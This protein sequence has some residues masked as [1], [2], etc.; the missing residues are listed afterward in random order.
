[1]K[2]LLISAGILVVFNVIF[3]SEFKQY[4]LK[5]KQRPGFENFSTEGGRTVLKDGEFQ[6]PNYREG[7]SGW[8]VSSEGNAEFQDVLINNA[9]IDSLFWNRLTGL[10]S[11]ESFDGFSTKGV[12]VSVFTPYFMGSKIATGATDDNFAVLYS[13]P[14]AQNGV[15][16]SISAQRNPRFQINCRVQDA[17][18]A[19]A[20]VG[21]SSVGA[22]N[23]PLNNTTGTDQ[24]VGFQLKS[25]QINAVSRKSNTAT[26]STLITTGTDDIH[27][28]SFILIGDGLAN[29]IRVQFFLDGELKA[30]HENNLPTVFEEVDIFMGVINWNNGG[31]Q[32]LELT[33]MLY[34][35]DFTF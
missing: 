21:L 11:F 22:T 6:S 4:Y 29:V 8:K 19:E 17:S 13:N 32:T 12:G 28:Y 1:M 24:Y 25:N 3:M 26:N 35:Q 15:G 7:Q 9:K 20:F 31:E 23:W 30:T 14:V 2:K 27:T 18:S 16:T 5:E 10:T 33:N 34:S